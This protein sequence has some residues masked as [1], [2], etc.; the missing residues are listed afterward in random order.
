MLEKLF[1]GTLLC[2]LLLASRGFSEINILISCIRRKQPTVMPLARA[3]PSGG[4]LSSDLTTLAITGESL[5]LC[6]LS[7]LSL[8]RLLS[9]FSHK[10]V[11]YFL[12]SFIGH[13]NS[14][15]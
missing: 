1:L 8:L 6:E 9:L 5:L 10:C 3:P 7:Q 12:D 11:I 4:V 14:W 13:L 2:I 15:V